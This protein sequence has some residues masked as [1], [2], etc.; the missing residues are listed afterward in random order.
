MH[1]R[2]LAVFGVVA[3]AGLALPFGLPTGVAASG[4][5]YTNLV[6]APLPIEQPGTL[7]LGGTVTMCVQPQTG[8][9]HVALG[10]TVFLSIDSGLFTAPPAAGGSATSGG[11]PLTSTPTA[12]TTIASCSFANAEQSGTVMDAVPITY[13]GPNPV[14]IN[15]R[16]VIVAA[17]SASDVTSGQCNGSGVCNTGTYVFSP[18]NAYVFS[19]SPIAPTASLTAGEQVPLTV[20]AM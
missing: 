15:G 12:F 20:T 14:P 2:A 17:D 13:T 9:M 19:P 16:D 6:F 18:V 10:A 1:K 3:F 5:T 11:T 7:P 4:P 8:G